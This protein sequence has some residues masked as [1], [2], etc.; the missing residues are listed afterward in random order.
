LRVNWFG[1]LFE[2]RRKIAGWRIEYNRERPH[3]SL[4]YRTSEE[5]AR[6]SGGEKSCGFATWKTLRVS[7]FPT[8]TAATVSSPAMPSATRMS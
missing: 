1:N 7:H 6:E 5:F 3:N 2:A 4:G 8:A